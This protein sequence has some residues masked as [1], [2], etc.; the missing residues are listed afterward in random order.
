MEQG[1]LH[2]TVHSHMINPETAVAN[3]NPSLYPTSLTL[4]L[5]VDA[6][7]AFACLH[8]PEF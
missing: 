7:T 8:F 5:T 2:E 6:N 3:E 4:F 1:L